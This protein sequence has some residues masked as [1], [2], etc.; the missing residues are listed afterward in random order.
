MPDLPAVLRN[1][2]DDLVKAG[3]FR[4]TIGTQV[5]SAIAALVT[6]INPILG[7]TFRPGLK[8]AIII[9]AIGAFAIA[10][11]ADIYGRARVTCCTQARMALAPKGWKVK[12]TPEKGADEQ[13]WVVVALRPKKGAPS[14]PE[15]LVVKAGHDSAW[16]EAEHLDFS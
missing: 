8:T 16:A 7:D 10:S 9:A 1:K 15:F 11:A 4:I 3:A 2:D 12:Y 5:A 13:G 14:T 6:G